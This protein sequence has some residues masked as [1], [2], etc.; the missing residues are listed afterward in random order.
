MQNEREE[1]L[2]KFKNGDV[3]IIVATDIISRGIDIESISLVVNFD[4]PN[5]AEDYIHRI[6]RTARAASTGVAFTFINE[7]DQFKFSKIE[8]LIGKPVPKAKLPDAIGA[9]PE[10]NPKAN[11]GLDRRKG[12]YKPSKKKRSR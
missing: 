7:V 12:K 2:R 3:N 9:G 11:K 10:Y 1:V 6:G 5:D 4:V 8:E